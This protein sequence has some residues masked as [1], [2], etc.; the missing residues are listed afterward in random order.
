M[1]RHKH[2]REI[3]RLLGP[4]QDYAARL[5]SKKLKITVERFK[6]GFLVFGRALDPL[7]VKHSLSLHL[8]DSSAAL[9]F[10]K[11]FPSVNPLYQQINEI[12]TVLSKRCIE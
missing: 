5:S 4:A 12:S 1:S 10:D 7:G 9:E 6:D 3:A 2:P 8:S 11:R